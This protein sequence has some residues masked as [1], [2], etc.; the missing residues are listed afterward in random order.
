MQPEAVE[1]LL[2][3]FLDHI[4]AQGLAGGGGT[5]VNG[6]FAFFVSAGRPRLAV[7]EAHRLS[8]EA[9]LAGNPAVTGAAVGP[10]LDAWHAQG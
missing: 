3:A 8:L 2:G 10:L 4:E 9:W 7:T 1:A 5:S 6:D